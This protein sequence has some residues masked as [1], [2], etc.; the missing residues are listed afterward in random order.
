MSAPLTR[1]IGS[2]SPQASPLAESK[3]CGF[4][5]SQPGYR[6]PVMDSIGPH[7]IADIWG[8]RT[9]FGREED[10][11]SRVDTML[12]DGISE[13]EVERW[14]QSACVLCSNGCALDIAVA[15]GRIVGV[16][17]REVDRIN[18][19]RLGPKGLYGWQANN[20]SERLTRPLLRRDGA[21]E[22]ASW[23]EA[24]DL[25]ASRSR[26]LLNETGPSALA[27]YTTGQL[28]L[29]DYY[30]LGVVVR[31]GIGTNHLDGN[32]RLCT[33]TAD[34]ALKETFG[35][36]GQ[37]GSY[38]DFDAC[39]TLF[40]IGHNVGETQTVLWMRILDRLHGP[41]RPRLVVVDPRRTP[42]AREVDLHL[43]IR[44]GT[45]L[46]LLNSIQHELITNGWIDDAFVAE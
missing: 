28:F 39:D 1:R 4:C 46:A 3:D 27:F 43:A 45:N 34:Y 20:S 6:A 22:E 12:A 41:D 9:P 21:L 5:V 11:P 14:V 33:A 38:T 23:D 15:D 7:R 16:R 18:H 37:P 10:W 35:T 25:V 13:D 19:G 26:H 29:E 36:D 32:T 24:L 44:N 30:T 42:A 31:G 2:A 17:G 8:T 40:L